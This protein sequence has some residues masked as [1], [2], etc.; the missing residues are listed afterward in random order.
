M[1]Y[2]ERVESNPTAE[3]DDRIIAVGVGRL[4]KLSALGGEPVLVKLR[5]IGT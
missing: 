2:P 1:G 5:R 3:A 4:A